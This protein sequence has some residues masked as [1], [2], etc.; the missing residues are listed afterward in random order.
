MTGEIT[1]EETQER[2]D[3][4]EKA[5][6]GTVLEPDKKTQ[7]Q[8]ELDQITEHIGSHKS[9]LQKTTEERD[10]LV[11]GKK[12]MEKSME[13]K[14]MA[15]LH[16]SFADESESGLQDTILKMKFSDPK[17]TQLTDN[18]KKLLVKAK[19]HVKNISDLRSRR[20]EIQKQFENLKAG[21]ALKAGHKAY[22]DWYDSVVANETAWAAFKTATKKLHSYGLNYQVALKEHGIEDPMFFTVLMDKLRPGVLTD[23]LQADL[24]SEL[25]KIRLVKPNKWFIEP[26]RGHERRLGKRALIDP[27]RDSWS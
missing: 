21:E 3:D 12:K 16:E 1:V 13:D 22:D 24:L 20:A 10:R 2:R 8:S 25:S 9:G 19:F 17:L 27:R 18:I 6:K 15:T 7:L 4:L 5:V 14:V 23:K 26:G 11:E